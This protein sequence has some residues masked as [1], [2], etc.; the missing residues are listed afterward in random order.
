MVCQWTR[1]L[2]C[3]DDPA[4]LWQVESNRQYARRSWRLFGAQDKAIGLSMV[5]WF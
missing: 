4:G 3:K 1:L 2:L 5:K